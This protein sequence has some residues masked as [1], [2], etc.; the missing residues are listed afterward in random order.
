MFCSRWLMPTRTLCLACVH[1]SV[2]HENAKEQYQCM[3]SVHTHAHTQHIQ[4]EHTGWIETYCRELLASAC[5]KSFKLNIFSYKH[6]RSTI[7]LRHKFTWPSSTQWHIF[8]LP[9]IRNITSAPFTVG[10]GRFPRLTLDCDTCAKPRQSSGYVSIHM[11][12][13]ECVCMYTYHFTCA[14]PRQSS[15]Y[16]SIHMY[17]CKCVCIHTMS[18]VR[19]QG[20]PRG[21]FQY[22][23]MYVCMYAYQSRLSWPVTFTNVSIFLLKIWRLGKRNSNT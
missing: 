19:S 14:K 22:I 18:P 5:E 3:S 4:R 16:V 13:C 9:F 12:V 23:C 17:V 15:G 1:T 2:C 10:Y 8:T 20:N 6:A 21:T 11:Y 7:K